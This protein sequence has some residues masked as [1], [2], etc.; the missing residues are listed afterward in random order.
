M[1]TVDSATW[2]DT[3]TVISRTSKF[4]RITGREAWAPGPQ[5]GA[6]NTLTFVAVLKFPN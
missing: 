3:R 1:G 6:D 2:S 4:A 5:F